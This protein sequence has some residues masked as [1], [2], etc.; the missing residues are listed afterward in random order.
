M[1]W[2]GGVG[3]VGKNP[4]LRQLVGEVELALDAGGRGERQGRAI[5]LVGES[6]FDAVEPIDRF[7]L[8]FGVLD[9]GG[10]PPANHVQVLA[11]FQA[12]FPVGVF[13]HVQAGIVSTLELQHIGKGREGQFQL[14]IVFQRQHDLTVRDR[15]TALG[16][17]IDLGTVG[18]FDQHGRPRIDGGHRQQVENADLFF[19]G[20]IDRATLGLHDD[21]LAVD[22]DKL[23]ADLFFGQSDEIGGQTERAQKSR[24]PTTRRASINA[25]Q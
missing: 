2:S 15:Q 19:H 25:S 9:R 10:T 6:A 23:A 13:P 21:V 5:A 1:H 3:L 14:D 7:F 8:A 24:P 22:G 16:L 12:S 17:A 11:I 20:N 18:Q 4:S